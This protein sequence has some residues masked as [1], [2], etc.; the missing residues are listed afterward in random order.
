MSFSRGPR[1][2]STKL[3][4]CIGRHE[5]VRQYLEE[6][7][8][9]P[10]QAKL[11]TSISGVGGV[12]KSTLLNHF[13]S[14]ETTRS[15][16]SRL[17][18][19][20]GFGSDGKR[21]IQLVG[22]HLSAGPLKVELPNLLQ[23]VHK[24]DELLGRLATDDQEGARGLGEWLL[25][26]TRLGVEIVAGN[27]AGELVERV[28]RPIGNI[29]GRGWEQVRGAHRLVR[30]AEE[31]MMIDDPIRVMTNALI[32]DLDAITKDRWIR[33]ILA[34]D[35]YEV[36]GTVVDKW[37]LDYLI[38]SLSRNEVSCDVR[39]VISGR[40]PIGSYDRRWHDEWCDVI[41]NIPL[42]PFSRAETSE[43]LQKRCGLPAPDEQSV[44]RVLEITA[45]LPLILERWRQSGSSVD[46][47]IPAKDLH[48]AAKRI[49]WWFKND[50]ERHWVEVAACCRWFD[51]EVLAT[52]LDGDQELAKQA[53]S[54]LTN[55]QSLTVV[56]PAGKWKLHETVQKV[57][58]GYLRAGGRDTE[59][60]HDLLEQYFAK[61]M[62]EFANE[63]EDIG[64][65]Y[66]DSRYISVL[67][68]HIYYCLTGTHP[69]R[70]I[71]LLA[72][73]FI[74][75]LRYNP[76]L[77]APLMDVFS[78]ASSTQ[79]AQELSVLT[80]TIVERLEKSNW[81][82]LPEHLALLT[83]R[84]QLDIPQRAIASCWM[85]TALRRSNAPG[86]ALSYL[87]QALTLDPDYTYAV[88]ERGVVHLL[89]GH[90]DN[91]LLDFN[92]AIELDPLHAGAIASRGETYRQMELYER[93]LCEFDL[94]ISIGPAHDWVYAERAETYRALGDYR[95]ALES[96]ESAISLNPTDSW[97]IALRSRINRLLENQ[98]EARADT[99]KALDLAE[100]EYAKACVLAICGSYDEA[101][102]ELK[103]ALRKGIRTKSWASHDPD[104]IDL[105]NDSRFQELTSINSSID[106]AS[107]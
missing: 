67:I 88:A 47:Y 15:L 105:R 4:Y 61:E 21:L 49:M 90:Y 29:V 79:R 1:R 72:G 22:E 58:L 96:I 68:E 43:Y 82:D 69:D 98:T 86:K 18:E 76:K 74:D 63:I 8:Q 48:E 107:Q 92:R 39:L 17:D 93:A 5:Y 24:Y 91:A 66:Q 84:Y 32:H 73:Y 16:Y 70:H 54:R 14:Y 46:K 6:L 87:D 89:L 30:T 10:D 71:N 80:H 38:P 7:N 20:S 81:T 85:G 50:E 56:G 34:F 3:P 11:V 45:G 51:K 23:Q 55:D 33:I 35:T 40:E 13:L 99:V 36:I 25:F 59:R 100:D 60:A 42:A 104:F 102:L 19:L 41:L 26:G 64:T 77:L 103:N 53:F 97:N 37:L 9:P 57:I 62:E 12:G 31:R 44:Q 94:A 27:T 52:L 2:R 95:K 106:E 83:K 75:A 65:T 78:T 101:I 28:G